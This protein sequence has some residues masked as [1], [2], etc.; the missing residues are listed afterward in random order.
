MQALDAVVAGTLQGAKQ[1]QLYLAHCKVQ[2]NLPRGK[3]DLTGT[4]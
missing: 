3:E 2:N 1:M 4:V